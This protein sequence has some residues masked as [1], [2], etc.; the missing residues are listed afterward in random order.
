MAFKQPSNEPETVS[1]SARGRSIGVSMTG[2]RPKPAISSDALERVRPGCTGPA[3]SACCFSR[4]FATPGDSSWPRKALTHLR[5]LSERR[6]GRL[7][8]SQQSLAFR[9]RL[10]EFQLLPGS[11]LTKA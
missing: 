9:F 2:A 11:N 1:T 3:A 7:Q 4:V 6:P 10:V 8:T 5:F